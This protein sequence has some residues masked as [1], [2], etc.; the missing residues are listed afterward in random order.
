MP[1]T[2]R[3][4]RALRHSGLTLRTRA[5]LLRLE[6]ARRVMPREAYALPLGSVTAYLSH[7]D[8]EIDWASWTFV[9]IDE[10]YAG[11]YSGAVVVDIG[12]HKGYYGAYALAHGARAVISYEPESANS[13]LLE[14]AAALRDRPG[15]WHTR[16]CAV[17]PAAGEADLHVMGAS[18]GHA[19]SPPE[20]FARHEV[21]LERVR[22]EALADVLAE[23]TGL[24]SGARVIV[25]VNI[26]GE[27]CPTVLGTPPSAWDGID[28]LYV[29][30]HPWATCDADDL[31][32]YL[33]AAGLVRRESAHPA[34]LRMARGANAPA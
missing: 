22:V 7:D 20:K 31:T 10:A 34:V 27:E 15:D 13:A 8:Y 18:W 21:G 3:L 25:K 28:E 32:R 24:A 11:N 12:A 26:E 14:R 2:S 19:L 17:G 1:T 9:A 33:G 5:G 30:T 16:R 6:V 29:E 23:A 4:S